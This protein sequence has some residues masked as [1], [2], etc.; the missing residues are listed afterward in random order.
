M[1][2]DNT[3]LYRIPNIHPAQTVKPA[4][5]AQNANIQKAANISQANSLPEIKRTAVQSSAPVNL[6]NVLSVE[7]QELLDELFAPG[8]METKTSPAPRITRSVRSYSL[9]LNK[10]D[11]SANTSNRFLGANIDIKG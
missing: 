10:L 9:Q 11:E 7:E 4:R 1:K 5:L 2:I 3:Y 8:A 6:K